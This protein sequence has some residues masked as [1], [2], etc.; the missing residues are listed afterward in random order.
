[1]SSEASIEELKGIVQKTLEAKG[2]AVRLGDPS[3]EQEAHRDTWS[4]R[5]LSACLLQNT[6][7]PA[8]CRARRRAWQDPR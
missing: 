2:A 6:R 3:P 1:M 4:R 5:G 8:P 7:A